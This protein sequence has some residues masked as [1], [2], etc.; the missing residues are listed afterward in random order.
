MN[1]INISPEISVNQESQQLLVL[2]V[3]GSPRKGRNSDILLKEILKGVEGHK[4]NS[5]IIQLREYLYQGC[6]GCKKWAVILLNFYHHNQISPVAL[7][8]DYQLPLPIGHAI[9]HRRQ[10]FTRRTTTSFFSLSTVSTLASSINIC[11]LQRKRS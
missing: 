7:P 9:S 8:I 2:G 6:I 1:L 4:V 3:G 10:Y 11:S 5:R